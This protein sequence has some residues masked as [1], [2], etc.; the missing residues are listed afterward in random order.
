MKLLN[1]LL[2]TYKQEYQLNLEEGLTKTT[3]IGKTIN[4]L[5]SSFDFGFEYQR[6]GNT[7]EV[8][9]HQISKDTLDRFLKYVNNLGWFPSYLTTP[10]YRGKWGQNVYDVDISKIRFEAKFDEEVVEN[11]PQL[12]YHITPTQNVNKILSIGLVPKSR[13]KA[14]YH[15]DRV[16]V[17]KSIEGIQKLAPQMYQRTGNR[18]F[19]ILQIDTDMIPGDYLKLYTDP[20]YSTE[21]FY[22]LNNIPPYAIQKI[23][24]IN[25]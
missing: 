2:E 1:I 9:F 17:G 8:T 10:V 19:T 14:S 16:Y 22:T 25:L 3:N 21:A 7:F 18:D 20:N 6:D 12:I 15:P 5:R 24:Q 13:S 11:I 23:K 4:I